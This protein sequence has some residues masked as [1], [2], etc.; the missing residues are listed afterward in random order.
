MQ[1][2]TWD[3]C[4]GCPSSPRLKGKS[5]NKTP[6]WP[7]SPGVAQGNV[8]SEEGGGNFS[9]KAAVAQFCKV[10][11][12]RCKS[13]GR[14]RRC[15]QRRG[16]GCP[17]SRGQQKKRS[18]PRKPSEDGELGKE[19]CHGSQTAPLSREAQPG[20]PLGAAWSECPT[21]SMRCPWGSEEPP[22]WLSNDNGLTHPLLVAS[23]NQQVIRATPLQ[24]PPQMARRCHR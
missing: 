23:L 19:H 24:N 2:K 6:S 16:R 12:S 17:T 13:S 5:I 22:S 1:E 14:A 18:W 9:P 3:A 7:P 8:Y 15:K 21:E 20:E 4:G 10:T 11:R